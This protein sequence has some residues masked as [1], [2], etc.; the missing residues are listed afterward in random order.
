M[1]APR[2]ARAPR[3]GRPICVL[4]G[5]NL[6]LLGTREPAIYGT[7]TLAEIE[8]QCRRQ[9]GATPLEFRQT[10]CSAVLIGWIHQAIDLAAAIVINPAA[11]TFT[12]IAMLDALK[13]FE[14]PLIEV[15]LSN[16]HAREPIYRRSNVSPI[17]TAVIAGLGAAGYR[18]AVRM[19]V[20]GDATAWRRRRS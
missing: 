20:E 17:A 6:D 1:S 12:S 5:P 2:R 19:L 15:H 16:I 7:T 8:A 14:G 13:M 18:A 4:N 10:N 3:P 11:W 9:A